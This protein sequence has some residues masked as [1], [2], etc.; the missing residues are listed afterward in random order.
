MSKIVAI[1]N[2]KGGVGKTTTA[3]NLSTY[4]AL[5]GK[6]I[7]L[8]DIDPQGNATSGLGID[9][10]TTGV[11]I[12][13]VLLENGDIETSIRDTATESL[14]LIPSNINL[15]GA[16]IELVS[17]LGREYRLKKA[18]VKIAPQYDFVMIDCP[19]SLGMLT[20]NALSAADSVLVPIQCEYY[21][22]EGLSQLIS[23]LTLV[24]ENLNQALSIEGIVL[25]M[26]DFRTK[27]TDE[28][29]KE[30]RN[31]FSNEKALGSLGNARVFSTVITRNIKLTEAPGFGKPIYY[32]DKTSTGAHRYEQLAQEFLGI[33]DAVGSD[34]AVAPGG[35][36]EMRAE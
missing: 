29:I 14:R 4:L 2:Q 15:V 31:F 17:E 22:L 9:K 7:L 26:A 16:E 11:T 24:K 18:L 27:L 12:Y 34:A 23:T 1:C 25:T 8:V 36:E 19:P 33:A 10:A 3:I 21:A 30:V 28:V 20:I 6:K 35:T 13:E 5:A 32:Y